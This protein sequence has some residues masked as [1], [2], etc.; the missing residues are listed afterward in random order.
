MHLLRN[1]STDL[2]ESVHAQGRGSAPDTAG[3]SHCGGDRPMGADKAADN[4][5][6]GDI[7]SVR[8]D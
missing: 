3:V 2:A 6:W 7:V 5:L 1:Y 4:V 8:T